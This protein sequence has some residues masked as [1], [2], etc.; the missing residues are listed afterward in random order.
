MR[1]SGQ[2]VVD[3]GTHYLLK[4]RQP[5][6][7][8]WQQYNWEPRIEGFGV[9]KMLV[10]KAERFNKRI[11]IIFPYGQYEISTKK[12]RE[13]T[14]KYKSVYSARDGTELF[15]TP[16]SSWNK[17]GEQNYRAEDERKQTVREREIEE[18]REKIPKLF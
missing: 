7:G 1:I 15:V 6:W 2:I 10:E 12:I 8:A 13:L 4:L 14:E 3:L 18:T 17:V 16:R 5:Y 9:S 11:R